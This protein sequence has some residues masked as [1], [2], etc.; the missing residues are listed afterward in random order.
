MAAA[1]GRSVLASA[2]AALAAVLLVG[3]A[4]RAGPAPRAR[5]LPRKRLLTRPEPIR[6]APSRGARRPV[7]HGLIDG[8]R[9]AA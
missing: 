9:R 7:V 5:V 2:L 6:T 1:S 3:P 4:G 8:Y